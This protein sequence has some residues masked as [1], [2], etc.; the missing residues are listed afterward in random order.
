MVTAL[1]VSRANCDVTGTHHG[2]YWHMKYG[3]AAT[4]VEEAE[5]W[6]DCR[7]FGFPKH[8]RAVVMSPLVCTA[9]H[10]ATVMRVNEVFGWRSREQKSAWCNLV[11]VCC[12][13]CFCIGPT[14]SSAE[15]L[16]LHVATVLSPELCW[17]GHK[18]VSLPSM[19]S[20]DSW[21]N[22]G[23]KGFLSHES[24]YGRLGSYAA[25]LCI[26]QNVEGHFEPADFCW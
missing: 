20:C 9:V 2:L 8:Q 15:Q 25:E 24:S 11:T 5:M 12:Y 22:W 17:T 1:V 19:Y 16:C 14:H 6:S 4:G 18:Q 13:V 3:Y 10:G 21:H 23:S 26:I 7:V